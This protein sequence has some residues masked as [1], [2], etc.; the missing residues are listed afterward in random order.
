M[1]QVPLAATVAAAAFAAAAV[2]TAASAAVAAAAAL[3]LSKCWVLSLSSR[4]R[5]VYMTLKLGFRVWGLG[6]WGLCTPQAAQCVGRVI[7][8]KRDF[9]LMVFADA[10]F[11]RP[12]KRNKL[13]PWIT[14]YLDQAHLALN[15]ETA[16]NP[17]P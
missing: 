5:F 10:R 7:R 16:V 9:A 4:N 8:S 1:R 2:A 15:T 11:S 13:P 12:D 3:S 6:F 14:R 17:K